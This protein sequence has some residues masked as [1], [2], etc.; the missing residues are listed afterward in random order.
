MWCKC[1]PHMSKI[2]TFP[3][4]SSP[5][6][7]Q[8]ELLPSLG[9]R[10]LSSI[11]EVWAHRTSLIPPLY[12]EVPVLSLESE[13]VYVWC[14][15]TCIRGI[16]F[17]YVCTIFR[18]YLGTVLTVRYYFFYCKAILF[19]LGLGFWCLI[20]LST[21][22]SYIVTVSVIGGRNRITGE[23]HRAAASH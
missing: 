15:C 17:I 19:V 7:K 5:C 11:R 21:N 3:F 23:I 4:F 2:L 20:S 22:F 6:Q 12:I 8:C 1:F 9:V 16:D 10:R 13:G 18:L 14:I